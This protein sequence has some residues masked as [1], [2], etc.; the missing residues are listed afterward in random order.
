MILPW[1][2][3]DKIQYYRFGSNIQMKILG[4]FQNQGN[5]HETDD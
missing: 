3:H 5:I 1:M 2:I 4:L